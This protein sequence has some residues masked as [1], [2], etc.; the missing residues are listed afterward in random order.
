MCY[1]LIQMNFHKVGGIQ[2]KTLFSLAVIG[3][4]QKYPECSFGWHLFLN[5]ENS[6]YP[7]VHVDF[8]ARYFTC[9]YFCDVHTMHKVRAQNVFPLCG[10]GE[11]KVK[12]CCIM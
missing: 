6:T 12:S 3:S 4:T 7:V 9:V 8:R 11:Q 2:N 10:F 1:F 5:L